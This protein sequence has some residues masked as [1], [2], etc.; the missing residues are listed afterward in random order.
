MHFK[1][2]MGLFHYSWHIWSVNET[3]YPH[4]KDY[5]KSQYSILELG[6][7]QILTFYPWYLLL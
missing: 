4:S 6:S 1:E 2:S 7:F 5:I 3:P